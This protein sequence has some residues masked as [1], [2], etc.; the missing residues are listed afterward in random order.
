MENNILS[1]EEEA[2]EYHRRFWVAMYYATMW[3]EPGGPKHL[4]AR[5]LRDREWR[6]IWET[7]P[8]RPHL[9]KQVNNDLDSFW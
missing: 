7:D 2:Y 1:P 9:L 6:I 8:T 4:K 3:H 5:E